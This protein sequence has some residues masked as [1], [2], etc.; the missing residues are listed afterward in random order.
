[1]DS[2]SPSTLSNLSRYK[3]AILLITG[4][5]AL[6][7][8][9]IFRAHIHEPSSRKDSYTSSLRRSNA[10]HRHHRSEEGE[11]SSNEYVRNR[12]VGTYTFTDPQG[13]QREILLRLSTLPTAEKLRADFNMD[14]NQAEMHRNLIEMKYLE[15]LSSTPLPRSFMAERLS[16]LVPRLRQLLL[17][18]GIT[19]ESM[20]AHFARFG[21]LVES[22]S[23]TQNRTNE[24]P[25]GPQEQAEQM[26]NE[27]PGPGPEAPQTVVE[28]EVSTSPGPTQQQTPPTQAAQS[29]L[30]LLYHIAEDQARREGYIHRGVRCNSCGTLPIRG[31]RYRC[32]NCADYDLCEA[33]EC[34]QVHHK[35]HLFY[36]VR[37]PAPFLANP[38]QTQPVWYPGKPAGLPH[39]IPISLSRRLTKETGY[40]L[41]E[42]NA[43]WDQFKCLAGME[44]PEDPNGLKRAI[45][46]NNFTK[47]I[48]AVNSP[49]TRSPT[50]IHDRIFMFY[51]VNGDGMIGFE[52]FV[53]GI[54][55]LSSKD[56]DER[57]V[58]IYRGYDIDGD[59]YVDR[60]DFLRIFRAYYVL[61]KELTEDVIQESEEDEVDIATARDVVF[62]SQPISSI[63]M[64]AIPEEGRYVGGLGKE[65]N[66]Q[67]DMEIVDGGGVIRESEDDTVDREQI[68][69]EAALRRANLGT[70]EQDYRRRIGVVYNEAIHSETEEAQERDGDEVSTH[71]ASLPERSSGEERAGEGSEEE[72][73]GEGSGEEDEESDEPHSD[74]YEEGGEDEDMSDTWPPFWVTRQ[75]VET[76]LGPWSPPLEDID[77]REIKWKILE[78]SKE[79]R[80]FERWQRRDEVRTQAVQERWRH[81]QFYLDEEEGMTLPPDYEGD[82]DAGSDDVSPHHKGTQSR[83]MSPRSRS[84]SKVRFQEDVNET[85]SNPSTSS[86]SIPFAER[87][88]GYEIPE[89]EREVGRDILYQVTQQGLNEMLDPLFKTK[90]DRALA[91]LSTREERRQYRHLF[92]KPSEGNVDASEE[93]KTGDEDNKAKSPNAEQSTGSNQPSGRE[94]LLLRPENICPILTLPRVRGTDSTNAESAAPAPSPLDQSSSDN[95]AIPTTTPPAV[96]EKEN[97]DPTL[98]QHRPNN[99]E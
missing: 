25:A 43:M 76:V 67:G 80:D 81:R 13:Q 47:C 71:A 17:D 29:L 12:V 6:Y 14:L 56:K 92:K 20:R 98:P 40:E 38:K 82:P 74:Y 45:D 32:S 69:G 50:L 99:V 79:R 11:D 87:W 94:Y 77:D 4:I 68:V 78:A 64:G 21:S 83:P 84:S 97:H 39:N 49:R 58:R 9:V 61:A 46:K 72:G 15:A 89:A 33:C 30:N 48:T 70:G 41:S 34:Q 19:S 1:M 2:S 8:L 66:A 35:T 54:A 65:R 16:R 86:R 23:Q 60:K 63:F 96:E 62:G 22:Q 55:C 31:V 26:P 42:L 73:A 36:K 44:W 85:R 91:V 75:D 7:A 90:E 3:P 28:G 53:K 57:I 52:E 27:N 51:D 24:N 37:I 59:G 5:A 10:I 18:S 95:P 88:G 93:K